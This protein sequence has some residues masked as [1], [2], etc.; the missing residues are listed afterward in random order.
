MLKAK[1]NKGQAANQNNVNNN[2]VLKPK[3]TETIEQFVNNLLNENKIVLFT[4]TT[5]PFC[6]KV[7]ELFKS[8]NQDFVAVE[9]DQLGNLN[10]HL[11]IK[12]N[13]FL[14]G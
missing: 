8:L 10:Y 4:K 2:K 7:K 3:P 13:L 6:A 9:L 5:C 11:M 12:I 1:T 14:T